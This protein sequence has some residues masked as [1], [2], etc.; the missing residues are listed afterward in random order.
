MRLSGPRGKCVPPD[1]TVNVSLTGAAR[2]ASGGG[3]LSF[4][5]AH[6]GRLASEA[7]RHAVSGFIT[8][9]GR[10]LARVKH[11]MWRTFGALWGC[12]SHLPGWQCNLTPRRAGWTVTTGIGG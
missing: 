3:S 1:G 7:G 2:A 10:T 4:G 6:L 9:G 5:L 8:L 11:S 12:V